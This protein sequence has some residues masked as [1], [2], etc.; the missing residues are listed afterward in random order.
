MLEG[1]SYIGE[2]ARDSGILVQ[3]LENEDQYGRTTKHHYI[4][5]LFVKDLVI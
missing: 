4:H 5:A 3:S 2:G 1:L